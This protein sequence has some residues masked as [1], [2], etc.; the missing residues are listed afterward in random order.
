M[1]KAGVGEV[2]DLRRQVPSD[3]RMVQVYASHDSEAR[4]IEGLL[5]KNALIGTDVGAHPIFGG[6]EGVG[7]DG[8]PP[9]LEGNVGTLQ[10]WVGECEGGA[11]PIVAAFAVD[12]NVGG[13]QLDMGERSGEEKGEK[14]KAAEGLHFFLLNLSPRDEPKAA[15]S[16]FMYREERMRRRR[17]SEREMC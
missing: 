5:A 12:M 16:I 15:Y 14:E 3:I 17:E 10:A 6:I 9:C 11:G 1:D 4:V 13:G 7:I 2:L 8:G